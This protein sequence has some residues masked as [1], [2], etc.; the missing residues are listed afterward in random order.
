MRPQPPIFVARYLTLKGFDIW[1]VNP[2]Y[3][4]QPL[5]GRTIAAD[6]SD[7]PGGV[8]MLDIFR[9]S[10]HVPDIV[11]HAL[12][13]MPDLAVIWMQIGVRHD[14]AAGR[15][16]A[17]G[18]EVVMDR[19]PKIEYQRLFGELRMGGFATGVISS[20][21]DQS[22]MTLPHRPPSIGAKHSSDR[23]TDDA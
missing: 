12:A 16:R 2:V 6:L 20:R 21:R 1:P 4:G 11:D 18:I 9:A 23:S 19:C 13:V 17:A 7:L 22:S 3:A 8:Q 14:E 15:A 10:E 5:F